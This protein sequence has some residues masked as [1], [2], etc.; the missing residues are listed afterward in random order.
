MTAF[1]A[2][3]KPAPGCFS[4]RDLAC[5]RGGRL[6]FARL[7]FE[8]GPGGALLLRGPNGSGKSTLLRCLAGLLRPEA[9]AVLW[10]GTRIGVEGTFRSAFTL[11]TE[12]AAVLVEKRRYI[13]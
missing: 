9:G 8:I 13:P 5:R 7:G 11:G 2:P 10:D 4:A 12:T 1:S 3:A 6:V